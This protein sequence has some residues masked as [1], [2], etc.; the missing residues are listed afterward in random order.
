[1]SKKYFCVTQIPWNSYSDVKKGGWEDEYFARA[2]KSL[3]TWTS[4]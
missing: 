3:K 2:K 4:E 1:M